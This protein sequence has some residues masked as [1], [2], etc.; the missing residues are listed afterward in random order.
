MTAAAAVAVSFPG[1][2]TTTGVLDVAAPEATGGAWAIPAS[3]P[4][5]CPSSTVS[6]NFCDGSDTMVRQD[7][8][9][10]PADL[11]GSAHKQTL[12]KFRTVPH[13]CVSLDDGITSTIIDHSA[14]PL[15]PVACAPA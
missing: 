4:I 7:S 11:E 1:A 15:T 2:S 12:T 13:V 3:L 5:T 10:V 14:P 8:V 9:I 6:Q